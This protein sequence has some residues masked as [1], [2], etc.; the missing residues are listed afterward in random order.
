MISELNVL[1]KL[2]AR[3][4]PID[5]TIRGEFLI[6]SF[7]PSVANWI[8][9]SRNKKDLITMMFVGLMRGE[10]YNIATLAQKT[11]SSRNTVAKNLAEGESLG[12]F[13]SA[14][15]GNTTYFQGSQRVWDE[16]L[17]SAEKECSLMNPHDR[18][19]VAKIFRDLAAETVE[20]K[21]LGLD[22]AQEV[23][24]HLRAEL[25]EQAT[26]VRRATQAPQNLPFLTSYPTDWIL[27]LYS[28]SIVT[29]VIMLSLGARS[30][31]EL[32]NLSQ[33]KTTLNTSTNTVRNCVKTGVELGILETERRG[34]EI[35]VRSSDLALDAFLSNYRAS[36]LTLGPQDLHMLADFFDI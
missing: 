11:A 16:L 14:R 8:D 15:D 4:F 24:L 18:K 33:I 6:G 19:T 10:R 34:R 31:G 17:L 20:R 12:I 27:F 3:Y 23:M 13:E 35:L 1:M 21:F 2:R 36:F 28:T 9:F 29:E 30:H 5:G 7:S 32:I 25:L 26:L 22:N